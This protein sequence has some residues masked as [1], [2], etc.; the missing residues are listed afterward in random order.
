[1][2]LEKNLE[3]EQPEKMNLEENVEEEQPINEEKEAAENPEAI[4]DSIPDLRFQ[5][6]LT[7]H[8]SYELGKKEGYSWFTGTEACYILITRLAREA[9]RW[10]ADDDPSWTDDAWISQEWFR[11]HHPDAYFWRELK[12]KIRGIYDADLFFQSFA[13][14]VVELWQKIR[15]EVE[16]G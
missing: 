8:F 10:G 9:E 4:E 2:N 13:Q 1:M 7:R 15:H 11:V 16:Q 14:V 6:H 5:R 3:E 12:P